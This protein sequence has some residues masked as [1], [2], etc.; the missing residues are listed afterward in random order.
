MRQ[1]PLGIP[2]VGGPSEEIAAL[3][4]PE[5]QFKPSCECL[6]RPAGHLQA[7]RSAPSHFR[8]MAEELALLEAYRQQVVQFSGPVWVR[9]LSL[10]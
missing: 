3:D 4:L 6:H 10:R 5:C 1:Q 2:Q 9:V 7:L 8:A